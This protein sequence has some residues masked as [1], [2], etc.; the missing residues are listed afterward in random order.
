MLA[1][2][3]GR[4][5]DAIIDFLYCASLLMLQEKGS[6]N[7]LRGKIYGSQGFGEHM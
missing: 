1:K 6:L 5:G 3:W 4:V 7:V 2:G